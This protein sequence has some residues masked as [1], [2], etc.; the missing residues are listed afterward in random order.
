MLEDNDRA[1]NGV[2]DNELELCILWNSHLGTKWATQQIK[3]LV[4]DGILVLQGK[5]TEGNFHRMTGDDVYV[6]HSRVA[7]VL[8]NICHWKVIVQGN[9]NETAQKE[10]VGHI[11]SEAL[12]WCQIPGNGQNHNF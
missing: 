1:I 3:V 4:H 10:Y 9:L 7:I 11:L 6:M 8:L 12:K 5:V 2:K